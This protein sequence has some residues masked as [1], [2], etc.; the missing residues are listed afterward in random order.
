[1]QSGSQSKAI[2]SSK[3]QHKAEATIYQN[4]EKAFPNNSQKSLLH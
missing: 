2:Y 1:M 3:A 4:A